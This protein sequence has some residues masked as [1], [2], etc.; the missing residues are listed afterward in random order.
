MVLGTVV[1]SSL[2]TQPP[3]V[4]SFHVHVCVD[5][6][7][8]KKSA[9]RIAVEAPPSPGSSKA[10]PDA[11]DV[12]APTPA[13]EARLVAEC[14]RNSAWRAILALETVAFRKGASDAV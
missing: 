6:A 4:S 7:G 5:V 14:K 8:A 10:G 1:E 11:T 2:G 3:F 13:T 12:P 9:V